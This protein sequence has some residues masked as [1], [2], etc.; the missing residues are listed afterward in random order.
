[1]KSTYSAPT[2]T[3]YG[4]VQQ[5]TKATDNSLDTDFFIFSGNPVTSINGESVA[6]TTGSSNIIIPRG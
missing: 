3:V 4:S 2:L 5:V 6:P 1:M